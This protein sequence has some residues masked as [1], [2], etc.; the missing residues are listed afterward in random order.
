LKPIPDAKRHV[1]VPVTR[2]SKNTMLP[3]TSQ[4]DSCTLF[5]QDESF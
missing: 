2:K 1:T 5:Q 4:P 3:R